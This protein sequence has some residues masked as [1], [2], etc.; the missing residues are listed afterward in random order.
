MKCREIFLDHVL[1][2]FLS[3]VLGHH[4]LIT[5][6]TQTSV[7]NIIDKNA[8]VHNVYYHSCVLFLIKPKKKSGF[9]LQHQFT[10]NCFEWLQI[11]LTCK[12]Q[13]SEE[14]IYQSADF[15]L[16][17]LLGQHLQGSKLKSTQKLKTI[18]YPKMWKRFTKMKMEIC[19]LQENMLSWEILMSLQ[20]VQLVPGMQ[21]RNS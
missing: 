13:N 11:I 6:K 16:F 3:L 21:L 5:N 12:N 7:I 15:F 9:T 18:L 8:N 1:F 14:L 2:L 4:A 19:H 10:R 20:Q 17:P